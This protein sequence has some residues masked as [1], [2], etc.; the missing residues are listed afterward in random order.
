MRRVARAGF[1][2]D[3]AGIALQ[4]GDECRVRLPRGGTEAHVDAGFR[5]LAGDVVGAASAERHVDDE[6]RLVSQRH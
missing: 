2:G 3:A 4:L 6:D 5:T 1:E